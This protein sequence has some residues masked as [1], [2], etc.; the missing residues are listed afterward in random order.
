MR[1][2]ATGNEV[3]K[4]VMPI[5]NLVFTILFFTT[6]VKKSQELLWKTSQLQI[7]MDGNKV[8]EI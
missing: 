6:I 2:I 4:S 5:T 8:I 1:S 3:S 7:I